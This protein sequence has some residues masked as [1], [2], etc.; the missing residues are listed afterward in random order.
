MVC[1]A[2]GAI[3]GPRA[4]GSGRDEDDNFVWGL[5]GFISFLPLFNWLAWVLAAI[6][7]E[8]RAAL[9]GVY[10]ALYGSPLLL[11]GLDWQDPWMVFMLVL[12]V[13]HVQAER[14]AQTEP[15]ALRSIRPV[16]LAGAA[17][18]GVMRGTGSLV[19]GL[20][21]VIVEDA[22][23]AVRRPGGSSS[24]SSSSTPPAELGPGEDRL[25]L[26]QDPD[27]L[28]SKSGVGQQQLLDPRRD[29]TR[30]PEL[31]DF[32]KLEL[33]QFDEQ[34]RQAEQRRRLGTRDG[35]G[36]GGRGSGAGGGGGGAGGD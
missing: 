3:R 1:Q 4:S 17:L 19:T 18:R 6:S 33:R 35:G 10:A 26:E 25:Q 27:L 34:L 16:G 23:R 11:R 22:K 24:S 28:G 7:D 15:E 8:D 21:G 32:A 36:G 20:G 9:Y 5:M 2:P 14:I 31:E 13:V 29:P 12:C 30:N